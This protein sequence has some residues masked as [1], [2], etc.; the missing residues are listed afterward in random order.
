MREVVKKTEEEKQIDRLYDTLT[1]Y[2]KH[3]R[4]LDLTETEVQL[5]KTA[6]MTRAAAQEICR[7]MEDDGR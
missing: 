3:K 6:L 5:L 1:S 2:Q 7:K 4:P